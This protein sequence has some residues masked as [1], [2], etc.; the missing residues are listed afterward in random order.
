[1]SKPILPVALA[2]LLLAVPS[3][4]APAFAGELV[5][6]PNYDF[7]VEV[8]GK[9]PHD[10][11]FLTADVRGKFLVDMPSNGSG[12]LIDLPARKAVALSSDLITR[13]E[14]P[15]VVKV[16]DPIPSSAASYALSIEGPIL[17][18]ETKTS[19]VRVLKVLDRAPQIGPIAL[20]DLLA[21]RAEYREAGRLYNPDKVALEAIHKSKK[22]IEIEAFFGT[23]CAHCKL[24]MPKFLRVMKDAENPNIKLT[25][26]GVPKNFGAEKGPWEGRGIQSIPTITVR[27]EGKDLTR[28][29]THETAVPESELAGIIAALR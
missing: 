24:F 18:F 14:A 6:R 22:P 20:D 3:L 28:L 17:S 29:G 19:K 4:T 7:C 2:A 5:C 15:G 9:Y 16:K 8:D 11:T 10:A 21:D 13:S 25:L 26:I 1:M 23:W 27:Y 12:L